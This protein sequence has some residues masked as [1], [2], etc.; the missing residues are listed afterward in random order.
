MG[1][2]TDIQH[3]T[4]S[5]KR[6]AKLAKN[7]DDAVEKSKTLQ[8]LDESVE[9]FDNYEDAEQLLEG[10]SGEMV[11]LLEQSFEDACRAENFDGDFDAHAEDAE[12]LRKR[13][14]VLG[15]MRRR[16]GRRGGAYASKRS[17]HSGIAAQVTLVVTRTSY[18]YQVDFPVELFNPLD[19]TT[20]AA[21]I[22]QFMPNGYSYSIAYNFL[23][24]SGNNFGS[25]VFTFWAN[26]TPLVQDAVIIQTQEVPYAKFLTGLLTCTLWT[27]GG[28]NKSPSGTIQLSDQNAV[29]AFTKRWIFSNQNIVGKGS[30][31]PL[32]PG[33]FIVPEQ[34][35]P[36]I[37]NIIAKFKVDGQR[38]IIMFAP[39]IPGYQ[40][41]NVLITTF[42]WNFR[43]FKNPYGAV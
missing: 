42:F 18:N 6:R 31:N 22:S 12:H 16:H 37:A 41:N 14:R 27:G 28:P 3:W 34:Y 7:Y 20:D 40:A 11:E 13:R 4:E 2:L 15:R 38:G 30:T 32:N 26:A 43:A 19:I 8:H 5:E 10:L 35:L 1:K 36:Y 17:Q 25:L 24:N 33:S 21:L 23:P 29:S 9:D 39:Y